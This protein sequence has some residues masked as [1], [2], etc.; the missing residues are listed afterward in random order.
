MIRDQRSYRDAGISGTMK[1]VV[2]TVVP[3]SFSGA[4]AATIA[5]TNETTLKTFT[6]PANAFGA[7]GIVGLEIEAYGRFGATAN[8]KTVKLK[9]GSTV[10]S[11]GALAD[12]A[13]NW[14]FRA[15]VFRVSASVQVVIASFVHDTAT[16]TLTNVGATESETAAIILALT[17]QNGTAAANDIICN[18]FVVRSIEQKKIT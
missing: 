8:N 11:S 16:L 9:F 4:S 7:N 10:I 6:L 12:N 17:G 5:D 14:A 13:K 18:G 3:L 2:E 1:A 15:V